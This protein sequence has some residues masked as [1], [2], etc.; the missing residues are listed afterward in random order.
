[1]ETG[2]IIKQIYFINKG[3]GKAYRQGI[4]EGRRVKKTA[5]ERSKKVVFDSAKRKRALAVE[6]ELIKNVIY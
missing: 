3:L 6:W 1:M 4:R 2:I 5:E